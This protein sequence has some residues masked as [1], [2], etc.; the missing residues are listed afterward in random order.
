M[1]L[2]ALVHEERGAQGWEGSAGPLPAATPQGAEH[3][4]MGR[5]C[6][7]NPGDGPWLRAPAARCQLSA[8]PLQG[9]VLQCRHRAWGA[10][11]GL[12]GDTSLS[13]IPRTVPALCRGL[14]DIFNVCIQVGSRC[15]FSHTAKEVI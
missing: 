3:S 11:A 4:D 10:P 5:L 2:T 7:G 9:T 15:P 8:E 13:I 1:V 12:S 14:K 6:H